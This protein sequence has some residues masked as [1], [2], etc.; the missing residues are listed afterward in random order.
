MTD[1]LNILV[2]CQFFPPYNTPRSF[3]AYELS[4]ELARQGNNVVVKALIGNHNYS[5]I[6]TENFHIQNLGYSRFGNVDADGNWN[7]NIVYRAMSKFGSRFDFPA[8]ELMWL[9]EKNIKPIIND[10]DLVISIA[11]PYPIHWGVAKVMDS[12]EKNKRP[13]WISD[14]GDP[15]M[16]NP[17]TKKVNFYNSIEKRW[18]DITDYVT[19]PIESAKSAY[20]E[21]VQNKINVIPQGFNFDDIVLDDYKPN[22]IPTFVFAGKIYPGTRDPSRFIEYLL[23]KQDPFK[24][25]IYT[26]YPS[27]FNKYKEYIGTKLFIHNYIPRLELIKELSKA[28]FLV[29]IQNTGSVQAPSKLIDYSL[30]KRPILNITS[31][32]K[33]QNIVEEFIQGIYIHQLASVDLEEFNIK[34]IATKFLTLY[35][36]SNKDGNRNCT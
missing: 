13:V 3:R 24:F 8:I 20:F 25:K 7:K 10:F 31:E 30:S 14:C 23:S 16:G 18:G 22:P 4:S 11:F 26:D 34:N 5:D 1:K 29:N 33:E 21:N 28:D 32:F 17:M 12:I 6:E 15:F 2:V 19:I 35:K 9:V 27:F 36:K